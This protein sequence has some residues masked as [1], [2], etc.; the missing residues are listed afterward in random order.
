MRQIK[1]FL[2]ISFIFLTSN[3]INEINAQTPDGTW[4]PVKQ[5]MGGKELLPAVFANQKL[6]ISDTSYTFIAESEDMGYVVYDDNKMDIYGNDGVND[7]KHFTA[8]FKLEDDRLTICYDLRGVE[9]PESF[10]TT[11]QPMYFMSVF[12]KEKTE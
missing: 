12:E 1:L 8:I 7:Q 11:D 2:F 6:I 10:D 9:Y 3:G 4:I 5:E